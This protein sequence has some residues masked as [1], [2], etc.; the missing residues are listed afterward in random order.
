VAFLSLTNENGYAGMAISDMLNALKSTII[1]DCME[2]IKNALIVLA[3]DRPA[4]LAIF[5]EQWS[6]ILACFSRARGKGITGLLEDVAKKLA[7]IPLRYPLHQA[8]TVSFLGEI[9]V[10]RE[11]FSCQDIIG[12]LA[13]R[14]IIAKRAH[15]LEWLSY[16]DWNVKNGI[17]EADFSFLGSVEFKA[18]TF[19][20]RMYEKKI[21]RILARSG[22]YEYELVDIDGIIDYGKQFFD[23]RFTGEAILVVG[24]FFKDILRHTQGVISIGPFA[25]MPTRVIE[26]VLSAEADMATKTMLE[27]HIGLKGEAYPGI[28]SLPFLSVESDGNPFPQ[29]IEARIEA[30][31]LQVERLH[32]RLQNRQKSSGPIAEQIMDIPSGVEVEG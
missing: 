3:K 23:V 6:R 21:K 2:D 24:V 32:S 9:F 26:A 17:Y 20:T 31:C 25:C 30:F 27:K 14:D 1:S 19:L 4:A 15:V 16:C 28:S 22:L 5:E 18:K 7:A 29:V 13:D 12:R 8:K 11:Y 10:R